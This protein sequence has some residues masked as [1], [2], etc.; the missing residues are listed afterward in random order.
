MIKNYLKLLFRYLADFGINPIKAV[1][2]IRA[3]PGY[4]VEY[5]KLNRQLSAGDGSFIFGQSYPCLADRFEES[6]VANGHYFHQDLLVAQR[7]FLN[8]PLRHVDVGSRVDGFVA[9][10]A[11]FRKIE[12]IDIRL[13]TSKSENIKYIQADMMGELP[14]ELIGCCESLSCLH[15]LE[16]FGLGRYGDPLRWDGH[17]IG[18]ENLL[19][20]LK[21]S[22]KLYLSIPIGQQR[23]EFN[24]HR[25]FSISYLFKM[26]DNKVMIDDFSFVDDRGNL[27]KG[28]KFNQHNI[29]TNFECHYGC[30]I[31]T[32][33]KT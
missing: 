24:A 18:F 23:I 10:I 14:D 13:L 21:P 4:F 17:I 29:E 30:G 3:L 5:R 2:S 22:G 9:H 27:N 20:M 19:S 25:V 31:F 7:V 16:H 12:C 1:Q 15:A 33:T 6:G 26:F 28:L 8:K 32:L 11:S